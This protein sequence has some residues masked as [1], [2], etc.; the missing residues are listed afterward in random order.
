MVKYVK[1][2]IFIFGVEGKYKK[3]FEEYD[4]YLLMK[5]IYVDLYKNF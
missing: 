3:L 2:W 5:K 1:Y 4:V